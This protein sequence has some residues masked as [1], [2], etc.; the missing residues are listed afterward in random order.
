L[1]QS[2]QRTVNYDDGRTNDETYVV[3]NQY[4]WAIYIREF[5]A[6]GQYARAYGTYDNGTWWC[7]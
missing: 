1:P 4:N 6:A 7:T 2:T 3:A 5:N